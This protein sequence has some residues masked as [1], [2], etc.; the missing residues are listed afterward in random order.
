MFSSTFCRTFLIDER[1]CNM[2]KGTTQD[3]VFGTVVRQRREELRVSVRRANGRKILDI[4]VFVEDDLGR[5]IP[6]ARGVSLSEHDWK[7][8]RQVLAQLTGGRTGADTPA[9]PSR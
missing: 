7:E 6:T 8:L 4:R 2:A 3:T 1:R 9:Q 5:M